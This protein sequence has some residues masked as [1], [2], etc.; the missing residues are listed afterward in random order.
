MPF[1][2]TAWIN[3]HE[4]IARRLRQQGVAFVQRDNSIVEC[5]DAKVLQRAA[6]ALS[7]NI[8]QARLDY[9]AAV[10]APKFSQRERQQVGSLRRQWFVQQ[11]EYCLNWVFGAHRRLRQLFERSCELSLLR[12]SADRLSQLFGAQR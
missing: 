11:A 9:W 10:L 1:V 2:V 3:G 6:N 5:A 12:L 8:I 7:A 4:F